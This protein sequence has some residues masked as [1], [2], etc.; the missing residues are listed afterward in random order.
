MLVSGEDKPTRLCVARYG[1]NV[2]KVNIKIIKIVFLFNIFLYT[3]S[4]NV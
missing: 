2:D 4:L 3:F 1:N